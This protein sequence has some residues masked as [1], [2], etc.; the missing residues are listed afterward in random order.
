M[1]FLLDNLDVARFVKDLLLLSKI[2][3][4]LITI[5]VRGRSEASYVHIATDTSSEDIVVKVA[6]I[7]CYLPMSI[8]DAKN[9]LDGLSRKK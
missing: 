8:F 6:S 1:L 4:Q 7:Y 2:D 9:I 5:I 3:S